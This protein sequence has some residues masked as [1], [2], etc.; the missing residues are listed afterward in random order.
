MFLVWASGVKPQRT[1]TDRCV[2]ALVLGTGWL[3]RGVR[4]CLTLQETPTRAPGAAR[5]GPHRVWLT[6]PKPL[7]GSPGTWNLCTRENANGCV[8]KGGT[9]PQAGTVP[10]SEVLGPH[11]L[12]RPAPP[13][14]SRSCC[15]TGC[16]WG[17]QSG[18]AGR[19]LLY[20]CLQDDQWG[21]PKRKDIDARICWGDRLGVTSDV[22]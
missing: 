21:T 20:F 6:H 15:G 14:C 5:A 8:A 9:A 13:L 3:G 2:R 16:L 19:P 17:L 22:K 12:T 10:P 11:Q 7:T 1:V 18:E 4:V